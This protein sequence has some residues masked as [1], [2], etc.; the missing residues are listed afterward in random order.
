MKWLVSKEYYTYH[1]ATSNVDVQGQ[2]LC[3]HR[4]LPEEM[5][6]R[7][8]FYNKPTKSTGLVKELLPAPLKK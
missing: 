5:K 4:P 1:I 3:T 8:L 2:G 6:S 7:I